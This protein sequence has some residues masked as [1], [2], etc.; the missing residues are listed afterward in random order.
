MSES[1][2]NG[3]ATSA[4]AE[5]S[6]SHASDFIR[7]MIAADVKSKK[8]GGKVTTRFPPEPNGYLHIG[9]A[10]SICL[11]FGV[12]KEHGG[13]CHLRMDDTNPTTEDPEYVE[14]IQRDVK[15]LGFDWGDKMFYASGYYERLYEL[16][17]KL[18]TLGRAYV[19]ELTEDQMSEYRGSITEPGKA[20]P[21]RDRTVEENLDR[22]RRMRKGEFK[23]GSCVLRAKID[24]ASPNM[25]MRDPPIYRIK[26]AHHYRT[27][28]A[29]CIYP[30]YDF[31][32]CLSDSFE[33][34]THSLCTMEFESARE[35]YDWVIAATEVPW[36]SRQ[37]EFARLNL[38]YT[39]MSKRKLLQL[40]EGKHVRG[41]DDPRMP[42][43]A[44]LRRRGVT[45]ESIREFCARIGVAKNLS[46][47][48][49][50][51]LEHV[52]REDL[53][54]RSPRVLAVLHPLKVTIENYPA[55]ETEELDAPYWPHDIPK[56]GS[57][58]VPFSREIYIDKDD[59]LE[60]PPKDFYRLAPGRAVR[61]RHAYIVTCKEVKKNA[62]GEV[63]ELV[64]T[65]DPATRGGVA[66]KGEKV[67]GTIQWVSAAHA[68]D[69]EV[70]VY[71]RLF[72][73]EN[74]G[75]G[76]A[77]FLTEMNPKSL[78]LVRA[79]LE[80]SLKGAEPG[81]HYQFER[82]GFFYVDPDTKPGAPVFNRTVA[83][84]DSWAK[85]TAKASGTSAAPRDASDK[86][87]KTDAKHD[88][89]S[90]KAKAAPAELSPEAKALKDA[91]GLTDEEAKTLTVEPALASLF[92]ASVAAGAKAKGA[93]ALLTN[94]VLGEL[95][96][97]RVESAPFDGKAVAELLALVDDA[98]VSKK[99]A[100]DVLAA[101][102]DGEGAPRAIV[103]KRGM[104]QITDSGA[105]DAAVD[106]VLAENADAVLRFKA[107][108]A[109]VMGALVGL[110]MKA[111]GGKANPKLV[112]D[113]V[114]KKL[115]G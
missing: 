109:N 82:L 5:P 6:P 86:K 60:N 74:P 110:T 51:L 40:V 36:V 24:M 11:N 91:H 19:C 21:Y 101:M 17:E 100:K 12:A 13:V 64:C 90:A 61:L 93:A 15:W 85:V 112:A 107:G 76:D 26:H 79:K 49:V 78:T 50:A 45:P 88:A 99:Q 57:R 69:A 25:K 92:T 16:A 106:K 103:D 102:F 32:H 7:E 20:S 73:V 8:H 53:S 52:I 48:D 3:G 47:V 18:I 23:E 115:E 39:V 98:T 75:V 33:G 37:T 68:L 70:R 81:E 83:L 46:T 72:S 84:K 4:H 65:Y 9:H 41:W 111:T 66:A 2:K 29:W 59:F 44:G 42:T 67:Q 30:L 54:P 71:D 113:L 62:A 1:P 22:F 89:G 58:K 80:P 14:A 97:R 63:T 104:R 27:G 87:P 105:I 31:A 43:I 38:T 55:N 28:D 95:R 108:N 34:I 10:K 35:L 114:K 56:E 94:D 77:D 96:G